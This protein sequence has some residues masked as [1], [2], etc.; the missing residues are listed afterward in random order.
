MRHPTAFLR[1]LI[2]SDG[3]RFENTGR[4]GWRAPRYG[5]YNLSDDIIAMFCWA[6]ELI[7][8]HWTEAGNTIYVSRKA[9]VARLDE[10]IGPKR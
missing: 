2:R 7:G 4:D 5:F 6:C 10:F 3:C 8:V 9:D 1:G